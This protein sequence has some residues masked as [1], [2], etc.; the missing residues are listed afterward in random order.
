MAHDRHF[1]TAEPAQEL[2]Q[3][4]GFGVGDQGLRDL[5]VGPIA[6]PG[7]EQQIGRLLRPDIGAG[8]HAVERNA[9]AVQGFADQAGL[10]FSL[11]AER[12]GCIVRD[13]ALSQRQSVGMADEVQVHGQSP[14]GK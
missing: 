6:V 12:S 13:P 2:G 9:F 11:G 8:D 10:R 3:F 14:P 1:L 7:L 4:A 5:H